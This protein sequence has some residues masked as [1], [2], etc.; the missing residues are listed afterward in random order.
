MGQFSR[1]TVSVLGSPQDPVYVSTVLE[2]GGNSTPFMY[3]FLFSHVKYICQIYFIYTF[4]WKYKLS[5]LQM[6][7]FSEKYI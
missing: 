5:I 1:D 2:V 3:T 6:Y 7:F 4:F